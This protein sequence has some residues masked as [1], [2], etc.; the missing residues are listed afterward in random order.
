MY[1]YFSSSVMGIEYNSPWPGSFET[2]I[3]NFFRTDKVCKLISTTFNTVLS[4]SQ[5]TVFKLTHHVFKLIY[6]MLCQKNLFL[7]TKKTINKKKKRSTKILTNT[8]VRNKI[9]MDCAS[10]CKKLYY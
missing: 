1:Y 4:S 2:A 5:H 9:L 3:S 7:F 8:Q 6:F 10:K